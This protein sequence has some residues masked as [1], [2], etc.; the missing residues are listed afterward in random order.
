MKCLITFLSAVLTLSA[1]SQGELDGAT[2]NIYGVDP[3]TKTFE[4]LKETQYAPKSDL[5]QSRF[6]VRWSD[7]VRILKVEERKSF[8]G[9]GGPVLT[10]FHGIDDAN[11]KAMSEG[12]P[13]VARVAVVHL[14]GGKSSGP[15]EG[16]RKIV[17]LFTPDAGEAPKSGLIDLN[18]KPV[19]V[20]LRQRH[21]RIYVHEPLTPA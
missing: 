5:G 19:K 9:L 7:D 12:R 14:G 17:S 2:G 13:F 21:A 6:T 18:G 10:D 3:T 16:H 4:L 1:W 11:A 8:A 20:N 15:E